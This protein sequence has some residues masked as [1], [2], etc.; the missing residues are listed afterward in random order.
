MRLIFSSLSDLINV[1]PL[2][3][4]VPAVLY[5][6]V[7]SQTDHNQLVQRNV[8][9]KEYDYVVIGGGSGGV[10]IAARLSEDPTKT[11]SLLEAG[12]A[13]NIVSDIL[14]MALYLQQTPMDWPLKLNHKINHVL[15][16]MI[17]RVFGRE[18]NLLA[19]LLL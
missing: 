5:F 14:L 7:K 10:V 16:S 11:V 6:I 18:V 1:L 8:W 13:E 9:H 2:A 4:L 15:V 19:A 12:K 17:G 3:P